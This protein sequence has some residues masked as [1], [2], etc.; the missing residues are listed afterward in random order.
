MKRILVA[1]NLRAQ[2]DRAFDRAVRLAVEHS[3]ELTLFHVIS[4]D[5]SRH[6]GAARDRAEREL[7]SY[8]VPSNVKANYRIGAGEPATEIAALARSIAADLIVLGLHHDRPV[9]DFFTDT[10]AH[11]VA[12]RS[13]APLLVAKQPTRG[14][15]Q[16]VLAAT[17][18][19]PCAKRALRAALEWAPSAEFH[20]LHVYRTPFPA[21]IH[22]SAD[23]LE[24]FQ[25]ARLSRIQDDLHEEMQ[26]FIARD[27]KGEFP[28]INL[29]LERNDVDVGIIKVIRQLE[30][31]L[32]AM[33]LSGFN[34]ATLVGSRTGEHLSH[35]DRDILV[36]A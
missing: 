34:F 17:D 11:C 32:L 26:H 31:D 2:A 25:S 12:R 30:P 7:Q 24:E 1:I 33:G 27:T 20:L 9:L 4:T 14:P 23:E 21:F 13:T 19:S 6:G 16:K 18:F 5:R 35:P 28:R 10:M 8:P 3:A 29:I 22:F 36:T 15:Y